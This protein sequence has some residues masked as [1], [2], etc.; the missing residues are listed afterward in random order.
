[1]IHCGLEESQCA[2]FQIHRLMKVGTPTFL[3]GFVFTKPDVTGGREKPQMESKEDES[4][5]IL[6]F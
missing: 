6:N 4:V 2:V 3:T 1:M 5:G